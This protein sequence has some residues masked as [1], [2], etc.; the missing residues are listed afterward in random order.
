MWLLLLLAVV[1][2]QRSSFESNSADAGGAIAIY[3]G[4]WV[5]IKECNF[6]RNTAASL[7]GGAVYMFGPTQETLR[8]GFSLDMGVCMVFSSS[9]FTDNV[10]SAGGAIYIFNAT[11]LNISNVQLVGNVAKWGGGMC[12]EEGA[13]GRCWPW[14]RTCLPQAFE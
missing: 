11:A 7:N 1:V 10:G 13:L 3:N 2:I 4:P 12:V 8:G 6:V 14:E 9:Q 5:Q